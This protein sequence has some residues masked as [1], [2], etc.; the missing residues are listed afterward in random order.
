MHS[1][2]WQ[3]H[4]LCRTID[5]ELFF[6]DTGACE[7]KPPMSARIQRWRAK[8]VCAHCPVADACYQHATTA[9]AA[10]GVFGGLD[11]RDRID[12]R[13]GASGS[14]EITEIAR[15]LMLDGLHLAAIARRIRIPQA[16]LRA[17]FLQHPGS[18][19]SRLAL[20]EYAAW[21]DVEAGMPPNTVA[22]Q[23]QIPLSHAEDMCKAM[24]KD[25]L[26]GGP[27]ARNRYVVSHHAA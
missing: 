5:R 11:Q 21:E 8:Q 18:P 24:D 17:W 1:T 9:G 16:T 10:F 13:R 3:D 20:A 27:K 22:R 6:D 12:L 15:R 7:A 25:P 4:A 19:T 2:G 26:Y 23:H 14:K